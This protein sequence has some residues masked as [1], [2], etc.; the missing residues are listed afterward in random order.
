MFEVSGHNYI[1]G[2]RSANGTTTLHSY[3]ASTGEALPYRFHQ[4]T[5][6]EVNAA[7]QAAA[8][9]Y[10]TFRNLSAARRAGFLDAI[11]T[12]LEALDEVF[13]SLVCQETALPAARIQGERART[14]G[15]MRLFATMLR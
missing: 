3:D 2:T 15:Q 6:D 8:T 14:S 9:A 10:P 11:A 4:A 7:A 13:I 5:T 12:E 1:A